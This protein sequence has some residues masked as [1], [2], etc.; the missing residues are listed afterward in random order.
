VPSK[1]VKV[2]LLLPFREGIAG[3][4]KRDFFRRVPGVPTSGSAR[5]FEKSPQ[6][7]ATE[8]RKHV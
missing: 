4:G 6:S 5:I 1:E 2:T 8:R 3:P 7:T